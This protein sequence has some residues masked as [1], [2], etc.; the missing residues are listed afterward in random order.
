MRQPKII[1]LGKIPSSI[2][3]ITETYR[4]LTY[5]AMI[6]AHYIFL[7]LSS[8]TKIVAKMDL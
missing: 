5:E 8:L 2:S 3:V 7:V 1:S 6:R 4:T